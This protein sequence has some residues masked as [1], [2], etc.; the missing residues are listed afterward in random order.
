MQAIVLLM[1]FAACAAQFLGQI[2]VL[3][4]SAQYSQEVFS[5]IIAIYVVAEGVR[6]R[7][8]HVRPA[9]WFAFIAVA[10]VICCGI[11]MNSV[12]SGPLFAGIRSYL[13]AMPVFFLP[14]VWLISEKTLRKQLLF[15][16]AVSLAQFPLALLQ[17]LQVLAAE[18]TSGDSVQGSLMNSGILT[19]FLVCAAC[20]LTG[21]YMRKQVSGKL[22]MGLLLVLLLPTT[23]N[24]TKATI[25]LVPLGL[26]TTFIL[27]SPRGV[28]MRYSAAAV[29]T[30]VLFGA[31]F[32]PVYD[33]F[34]KPR[35]GYGIVDF[36]M[37]D[38]RV[39]GYLDKDATFG[40]KHIGMVDTVV[41][42]LREMSKDIP[43][44]AFG[45]GI[46]NASESS[47]GQQFEGHYL[48]KFGPFLGNTAATL[49]VETGLLGIGLVFT[50]Y[51]LIF[52]DAVYLSARDRGLYGALGVGWMG[53]M[54]VMT[55][56][57]FY[58]PLIASGVSYLFWYMSGVVAARRTALGLA[59]STVQSKPLLMPHAQP[60]LRT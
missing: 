32:V 37:M 35:W 22:F 14:A 31:I 11:A 27:G 6:H 30:L 34:M 49:L 57:T 23:L 3:P 9:M 7:F 12:A 8:R 47:L 45:V 24:E 19:V 39:E 20:V 21:M 13:R 53:A 5:A 58:R 16:L 52:R 29:G 54:V 10:I 15:L 60:R 25:F 33:Y 17:R 40:S 42:P 46:G 59:T 1:L 48:E 26:M 44:L 41:V 28:R 2:H 51:F 36:F 55:V 50:L 18:R 38:G 56:A 4:R 43:T